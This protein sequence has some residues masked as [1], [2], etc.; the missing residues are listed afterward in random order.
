MKKQEIF[1]SY[2]DC[3]VP[4]Y[5]K[6]PLIFVKGKGSWLWDIDGKKYLDF[7][8]GWGVGSLGHCHPAVM[9]AVRDQVSK[10]VFV[11]NSYYNVPQ[12][13]LAKELNYWTKLP[14][15]S[16]FGNSGA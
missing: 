11:P 1:D 8:P 3:V 7:F 5:N 2:K 9:N 14:F 15:K 10:L 13:R 16:F 12:A 4:S 6:T